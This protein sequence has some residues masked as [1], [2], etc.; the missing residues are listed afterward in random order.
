MQVLTISQFIGHFHPVLVHLPIGILVLGGL[1]HLLSVSNRYTFLRPAVGIIYL[2]GAAGAIVSCISGYLLSQTSDYD[3]N[4]VALHQWLGIG[5]AVVALLLYVLL[6]LQVNELFLRLL[7]II[8]LIGITITGHYGGSLTHGSDYLFSALTE[9]VSSGAAIP[10]IAN[11]QQAKV[12]P[13]LV[14]P[15]LK[16]RCYNCHGAEK[17]KG[18]LRVDSKEFMIQ[19]GESGSSLVAGKADESELIK[20]LL[21]PLDNEDHMPPKEKPQLSEEEI[22]LLKWWVS[23][24]A[25]IHKT[26]EELKPNPEMSAILP[27]FQSGAVKP[28]EAKNSLLDKEMEEADAE[29]L[30]KLKDAGIVVLPIH[31]TSNYLSVNFVTTDVTPALLDELKKLNKQLVYLELAYTSINDEDMKMLS[32]LNNLLQLNL[33]GTSITDKGLTYLKD[34]KQLTLLNLVETKVSADGVSQ[35]KALK[36]LES[37]YL[38]K[39]AVDKQGLTSLKTV[40]P[41]SSLDTGG[42]H[43]PTLASDTTVV[44]DFVN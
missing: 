21:L 43:V 28:K 41:N 8:I 25:D 20:R 31:Q 11:I 44:K 22:A 35:L 27:V 19:G 42:Y 10:P 37:I 18:K 36:S 4:L 13:Q 26:V 5:V 9:G 34:L 16:N 15:L 33:R 2:L 24:G 6:R 14:E 32:S 23:Q 17:Q 38:Y 40:F 30:K 12:Y 39:T 7:T 29:A 1:F 3:A